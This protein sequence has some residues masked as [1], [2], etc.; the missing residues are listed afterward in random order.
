MSEIQRRNEVLT[1]REQYEED[2]KIHIDGKDLRSPAVQAFFNF[3]DLH[4]AE[5]NYEGITETGN[6]L[7]KTQLGLDLALVRN[8]IRNRVNSVPGYKREYTKMVRLTE[9]FRGKDKSL[10]LDER[11][12]EGL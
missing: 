6:N 11:L 1:P 5:F 10:K 3:A 9:N 4:N 7:R 12:R 2:I 8:D